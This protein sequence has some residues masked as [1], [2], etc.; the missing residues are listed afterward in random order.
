MTAVPRG[1]GYARIAIGQLR[2]AVQLAGAVVARAARAEHQPRADGW[3]VRCGLPAPCP[4]LRAART[5]L[6]TPEYGPFAGWTDDEVRR[7]MLAGPDGYP[8]VTSVVRCANE[9][10]KPLRPLPGS[11]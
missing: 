11:S 4:E 6:G 10:A 3:C 2:A 9:T 7:E 5:V 8:I 1:G